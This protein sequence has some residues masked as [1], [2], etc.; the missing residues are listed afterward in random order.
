MSEQFDFVLSLFFELSRQLPLEALVGSIRHLIGLFHENLNL[1]MMMKSW[2]QALVALSSP[3]E[4]Q[5]FP[6]AWV[7]ADELW[8][9]V[10]AVV[11]H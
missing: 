2:Q 3:V 11:S 7:Q 1:K 4:L 8:Q 10:S 6:C 5:F 9:V